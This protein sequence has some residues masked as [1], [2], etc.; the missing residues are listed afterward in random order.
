MHVTLYLRVTLRSATAATVDIKGKFS[1]QGLGLP[2]A[3][4]LCGDPNI[5]VI[6]SSIRGIVRNTKW[7]RA[8][9]TSL[10]RVEYFCY[11]E[12]VISS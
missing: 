4:L 12:W 3:K 9:W 6:P 1:K 11:S 8:M 5:F 7:N 2:A 10:Y